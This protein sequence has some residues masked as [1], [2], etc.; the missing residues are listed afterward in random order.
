MLASSRKTKPAWIPLIMMLIQAKK[1]EYENKA[2]LK[3]NTK[4]VWIPMA[5]VVL[6]WGWLIFLP[7]VNIDYK[8]IAVLFHT[9]FSGSNLQP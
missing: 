7:H 3:C 4:S 1:S 2:T 8:N 5:K 6:P 9:L